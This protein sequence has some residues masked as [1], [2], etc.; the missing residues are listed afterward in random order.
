MYSNIYIYVELNL[1]KLF[2]V[3]IYLIL[4]KKYD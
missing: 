1:S 4:N 2:I 3:Q